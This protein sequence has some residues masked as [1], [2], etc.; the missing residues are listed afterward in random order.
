M[1]IN[2]EM[3]KDIDSGLMQAAISKPR[4]TPTPW[5]H[6][7]EMSDSSISG[8]NGVVAR[9]LHSWDAAFIVRAVNAHEELLEA[10]KALRNRAN[11]TCGATDLME[12]INQ[13]I[14]KAEGK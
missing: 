4:H 3:Q 13:A 2:K 9:A 5:T 11:Q 12:Q 14:A 8:P 7:P 6:N 1:K 10:L